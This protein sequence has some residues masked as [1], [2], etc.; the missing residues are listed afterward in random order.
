ML[1]AVFS[2]SH[3]NSGP[4][5]A[6]VEKEKPDAVIFLGDGV[7]DAAKL[8][9]AH[10]ELPVRVL[11]GNCDRDAYDVE[12]SALFEFGGVRIFA[13]HGHNHGVKYGMT[14]FATSV[15]CSGA[16]LGLYGHT[17]RPLWNESEGLQFLNPGSIGN[18]QFPTYAIISA[19]NGEFSCRISEI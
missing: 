12:E 6:A 11:R 16:K 9:R 8:M 19:D 1:L 18:R 2:D 17:H 14:K 5:I 10:P 15:L 13:A 3:G 7:A 4:M